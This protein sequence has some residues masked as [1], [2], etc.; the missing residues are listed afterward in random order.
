MKPRILVAVAFGL[1]IAVSTAIGAHAQET[2][3]QSAALPAEPGPYWMWVGD[4]VF[5]RSV[6]VDGS[7][8]SF[9]GQVPAGNGIIAPHRAP[10]GREIY[11]AE[12]YYAHGTR[13]AR[14]DLVSVRDART[15]AL[16]AEI[17]IPPKRSE[18][19]SWIGGSALSDDG[20][21]LAVANL[22]PATS[23]SIVDLAER[24][25]ASEIET[26]GCA[27]VYAAGPRRFFSL[28]ADGTALAITVDDRG[29]AAAKTKTDRFFDPGSDPVIE[30]GV[31]LGAR[32]LFASFEGQVHAIDVSDDALRVAAPWPLASDAERAASWRV[33]GAQPLAAHAASGRLYALMHQG[34]PDSHK[35]PGTEVWVYDV[36]QQARVA[37]IALRSP[38][39]ALATEHA[40]LAPGGWSAWLAERVLPNEGV[41]RI[42]VTPGASPQLFVSTQFPPTL[43]LYDAMSGAHLRDVPGIGVATSLVQSFQ[44]T[45]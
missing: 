5:R 3:G 33:G 14:T 15:L 21:F 43:S 42:A 22:N 6:I 2:L 35:Q 4:A 41:E 11:L 12:T 30:K 37:R 40:Q 18:H 9:R 31:R 24:R 7:D 32:W 25:F 16:L 28:C 36:A 23:I 27:L 44:G 10:G 1:S 45:P 13:G 26:P 19:T 39:V 38:L 34:G 17:E 29:V 20:R 8:G